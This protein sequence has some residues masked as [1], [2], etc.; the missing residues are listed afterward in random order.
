VA[1]L[2]IYAST[3]FHP[4]NPLWDELGQLNRYVARVQSVLQRGTPA[5]DVLLYWPIEDI[6]DNAK[7]LMLQLAVHNVKWLYDQPVGKLAQDLRTRGYQFDFVSDAQLLQ[8]REDRGELA[9]Q[10][11]RYK[12]LV[13]PATR[14]MPASTLKQVAKLAA[15]GVPVIFQSLPADV[16]GYGRL[17]ARRAEFKAA[18]A[19]IPPAS[20]RGDVIAALATLPAA[21]ELATDY[22]LSVIR[23]ATPGGRD[24]FFANLSGKAFDGWI[25]LSSPANSAVI[26]DPLDGVS[27]AAAIRRAGTTPNSQVFL[28]L[29]PGQ[30]LLVRTATAAVPSPSAWPYRDSAAPRMVTGNWKIEFVKGGPTLPPA[31]AT[32]Q[33]KSWTELGGEEAG[34]FAGTARY[35]VE[36]DAPDAADD[37]WLL[38]LGDV[39]EVARVRLNGREVGAAWAVPFRIRLGSSLQRGRNLL[40]IDVTNLAANRIRDLDRRKVDWRI[41]HEINY[42]NINYQPFDAASWSLV[43]S[44]LLGPVTLTPSAPPIQTAT[45]LSSAA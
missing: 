29:A 41:M 32:Q 21:R 25:T 13:V 7:G 30:S 40:E 10:G 38:D 23:R 5:N 26:L 14:R 3:E 4:N 28:Q 34:A 36:F 16:P 24:Y 9:T 37:D 19:T 15:A 6:F 31:I 18:L 11:S 17:E 35:R 1:R 20:V 27:G 33:L 12:V 2:A 42:V 44:G 8:T 45:K 39:R 43:P 22:G